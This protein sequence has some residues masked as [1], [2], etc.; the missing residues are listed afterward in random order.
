MGKRIAIAVALMISLVALGQGVYWLLLEEPQETTSVSTTKAQPEQQQRIEVRSIEG[1]VERQGEGSGWV[2]LRQGERIKPRE[3]IRTDRSGRAVLDVGEAATVTVESQSQFSV[4]EIA[5]TAARVR[6]DVGRIGAVVHGRGG[7]TLRVESK[8]SDMVAETDRGEFNVLATGN[9]QVS[10][11]ARKG[12]VRLSAGGKTVE[13][14]AGQQSLVQPE[15]PPGQPESIPTTLFLKVTAPTK[16]VQRKK[17]T[18]ISGR[19]AP[20]AV[21]SVNGVRVESD[22]SGEFQAAV[23]LNEGKN[24]IE[25]VAEDVSG[26]REVAEVPMITVK[27][28]VSD[29]RSEAAQWGSRTEQD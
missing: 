18:T 6:I 8:G 11:A 13:V 4:Q 14:V 15:L 1:K 27:S 2:A 9:G 5:P 19:S 25:V 22:L 12:R 28:R 3:P 26:N 23:T 20:G 21:I 29:V 17:Q 24:Q 10:V 16:H 7:T